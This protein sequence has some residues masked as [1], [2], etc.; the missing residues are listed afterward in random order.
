MVINVTG[1]NLD[2]TEAMRN[3]IHD[4]TERLLH[5]YARMESLHAILSIEKYR[6]RAEIVLQ[7]PGVGRVEAAEESEDMYVSIDRAFER[8]EKQV[9]KWVDR[10]QKHN[11]EGLGEIEAQKDTNPEQP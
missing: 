8:A 4:R 5:E 10:A 7:G 3:H 2:I 9:R 11:N 6:H 1:R